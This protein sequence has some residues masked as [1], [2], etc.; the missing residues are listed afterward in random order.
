MK[1]MAPS[2]HQVND[3]DGMAGFK[4]EMMN[5]NISVR[6]PRDM[7]AIKLV[8]RVLYQSCQFWDELQWLHLDVA[9]FSSQFFVL[10]EFVHRIFLAKKW[11]NCPCRSCDDPGR[12]WKSANGSM[13]QAPLSKAPVGVT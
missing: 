13:A 5:P 10:L 9:G 3:K 7:M 2:R 8:G 4:E 6:A 11:T 1:H 12:R